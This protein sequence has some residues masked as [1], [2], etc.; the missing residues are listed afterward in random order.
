MIPDSDALSESLSETITATAE[1]PRRFGSDSPT[2]GN[3][4]SA[5]SD[6][7]DAISI[8]HLETDGR[9]RKNGGGGGG[10]AD[11]DA[12]EEG[13]PGVEDA[14]VQLVAVLD[15]LSVAAQR[16]STLLSLVSRGC[17]VSRTLP[18]STGMA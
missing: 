2:T 13:A 16:A 4:K 8:L 5:S 18:Q 14:A 7:S 10:I 6:G 12:G 3:E 11:G 9:L 17:R 1:R 15:P